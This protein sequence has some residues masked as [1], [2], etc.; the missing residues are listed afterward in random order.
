M[1]LLHIFDYI[2]TIAFAI[3][4]ALLGV[5]KELDIFGVI[6]LAITTAVGGGMFR[7]IM[8]GKTPPTT[9]VEPVYC[10]LSIIFAVLTFVFYKRII[11]LHNI[12]LIMD[13][14]GLGVFTALGS[15]AALQNGYDEIFV[16]VSMGLITGVGGGILRDV[17]V[18]NIPLVFKKEIYAVASI[19]GALSYYFANNI[20]PNIYA[21]YVCLLLTFL[22]RI[23][24]IL[25][26]LNLPIVK[27]E[28]IKYKK[29]L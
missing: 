21:M 29:E 16:V 28:N 20:L 7:D 9:L 18:N 6:F 11:K 2:G 25:H 24:A 1:L 13:A 22:L 23:L 19:M 15:N 5:K 8:I 12:I 17:F 3:S 27:T 10:I 14:I 26:K 4:G